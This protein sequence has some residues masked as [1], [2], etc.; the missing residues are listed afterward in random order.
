MKKLLLFYALTFTGLTQGALAKEKVLLDY[1]DA[2]FKTL[3]ENPTN[4][5]AVKELLDTIEELDPEWNINTCANVDGTTLL[6]GLL[7]AL[8]LY[9]ISPEIPDVTLS[10]LFRYGAN[11]KGKDSGFHLYESFLNYLEQKFACDPISKYEER[12]LG[13]GIYFFTKNW[14]NENEFYP[15]FGIFD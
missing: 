10:L 4:A 12:T 8:N 15:Q 5:K 7:R 11:P 1:E 2:L 14:L 6:H 13:E 3:Y 9:A